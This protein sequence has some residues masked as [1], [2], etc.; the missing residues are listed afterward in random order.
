M[1]IHYLKNKEIDTKAWDKCIAGS[2]NG[3]LH[4]CSWYLDLICEKW[5]ALVEDQYK[6]VMPLAIT[7]RWGRE[8]IE[9]PLFSHEL[10]IFSGEPI[11]ASKTQS[12][13]ESV[14]SR[15]KYYRILLNKYNPI[16]SLSASFIIRKKYELDLIKPYHRLAG[17]FTPE[18]RSKLNLAMARRFTLV[19][20]LSVQALI[21]FIT[22]CGISLP[23][24]VSDHN[25][26]LLRLI[27]AGLTQY[28]SGELYGI[29]DIHNQL[30]SVALFTWYISRLY[31]Q[32][33]VTPALHLKDF[34]HLFLIDRFIEKYAETNST[35]SFGF[36]AYNSDFEKYIGFSA[37]ES[38]LVEITRNKLPFY[39]KHLPS[40]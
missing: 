1:N 9:L 19:N 12:F 38:H 23:K 4:A 20:G 11:T 39:I 22:S 34:P 21:N 15:F 17:D 6:T 28:K 16:Q 29:F 5:D 31:L 10:G 14:P 32:F 26:R 36:P 8:I 25:F 27:I 2:F 35:L 24:K 37:R 33:Q 40:R 13:I 7:R 18:L 3:T 30:A